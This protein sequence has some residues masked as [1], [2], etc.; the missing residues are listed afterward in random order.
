MDNMAS[1]NRQIG[2]IDIFG[3]LSVLWKYRVYI[4]TGV[5]FCIILSAIINILSPRY[6]QLKMR[7]RP[8]HIGETDLNIPLVRMLKRKLDTGAYKRSIIKTG[9]VN[10]SHHIL[11]NNSFVSVILP[12]T[13]VI[14]VTLE[15]RKRDLK[16]GKD[17][18]ERLYLQLQKDDSTYMDELLNKYDKIIQEHEGK[19]NKNELILKAKNQKI[20]LISDR[21]N[22]IDLIFQ[23][24]KAHQQTIASGSKSISDK[25]VKLLDTEDS[26][27]AY[28]Y[29]N[30]IQQNIFITNFLMKEKN[31][32]L[33]R[34]KELQKEIEILK[35]DNQKA[36]EK[37][38]DSKNIRA[39]VKK[40]SMITPPTESQRPIRPN[41]RLN[42]LAAGVTGFFLMIL[43]VFGIE[44][45]KRRS[46]DEPS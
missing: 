32:E 30:T 18:L 44:Y 19:A 15:V 8:G 40:L 2:E 24:I 4:I 26:S 38:N 1:E 7:V 5:I 6:Y 25:V 12:D 9:S 36:L 17:L 13:N 42:M 22:K 39:T 21:I 46:T 10:N 35:I 14:D 23:E 27:L 28:F 29:S 20:A 33:Q 16:A 3:I 41:I 34:T 45:L 11:K 31:E 37:M 43:C